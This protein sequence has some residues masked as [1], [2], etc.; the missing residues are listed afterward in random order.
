MKR[1]VEF[2]FSIKVT[3]SQPEFSLKSM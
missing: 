3:H 2:G 1:E